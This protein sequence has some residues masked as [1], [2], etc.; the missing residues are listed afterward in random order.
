MSG[1]LQ[2][3]TLST[4]W[5]TLLATSRVSFPVTNVT[6]PRRQHEFINLSLVTCIMATLVDKTTSKS[7]MHPGFWKGK[8]DT[9]LLSQWKPFSIRSHTV[10]LLQ[11]FLHSKPYSLLHR[12]TDKT[13][14]CST[15][16]TVY[17]LC[18]EFCSSKYLEIRRDSVPESS[19]VMLVESIFIHDFCPT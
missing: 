4:M 12:S 18:M 2:S 11:S 6:I 7:T 19:R 5:A 17:C 16:R 13:K 9:C 8:G 1:R 3:R 10:P 15:L 14:F